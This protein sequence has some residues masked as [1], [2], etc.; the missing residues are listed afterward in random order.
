MF[1]I[2][3]HPGG[4]F[5]CLGVSLPQPLPQSRERLERC[6]HVRAERGTPITPASSRP[7]AAATASARASR[8]SAGTP[9]RFGSPSRLTCS[10]TRNDAVRSPASSAADAPVASAP[11]SRTLSTECTH[12]PIAQRHGPC[13]VAGARSCATARSGRAPPPGTPRSW[14]V[15]LLTRFS[16]CAAPQL[17]QQ[18]CVR[19]RKILG[20][21]Q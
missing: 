16:E 21:G 13:S 6:I 10:S 12:V 20:D 1:E 19:R 9:P 2:T 7:S 8:P 11:A 14:R 15:L 3:R 18:D 4:Q 5:A 17:V